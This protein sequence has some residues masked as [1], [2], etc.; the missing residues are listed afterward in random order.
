M[1][2]QECSESACRFVHRTG[3]LCAAVLAAAAWLTAPAAQ[4]QERLADASRCASSFRSPPGGTTDISAR[5]LP[6]S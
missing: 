5:V 3:L 1:L 6:T 2:L 4:A